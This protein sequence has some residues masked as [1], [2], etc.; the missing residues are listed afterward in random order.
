MKGMI[1]LEHRALEMGIDVLLFKH[2]TVASGHA[3]EASYAGMDRFIESL[4][5]N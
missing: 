1:G 4:S 3:I 5:M 2:F